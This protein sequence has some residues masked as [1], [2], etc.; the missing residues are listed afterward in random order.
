M[1]SSSE[2]SVVDLPEPV[3]PV[4]STS[5]RGRFAN[6]FTMAGMCSESKSGMRN[7]MVRSTAPI[8]FRWRKTFILKRLRPAIE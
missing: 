8:A 5:P 2:A 1:M 3:G 7:G 4:T 6:D